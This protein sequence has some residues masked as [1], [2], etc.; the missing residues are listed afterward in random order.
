MGEKKEL[1]DQQL[2]FKTGRVI[3]DHC[4]KESSRIVLKKD[5]FLTIILLPFGSSRRKNLEV[6]LKG[7]GSRVEILGAILG[8]KNEE[9]AINIRT[10]HQGLR[11]SA[12]SH[13]RAVLF[14][15]SQTRFLGMIRIEKGANKTNSLLENR[16]L[17][18]GEKAKAT[19]DPQLEIEADEVKASHAATIG[20]VNDSQI[21]YLQS[22]G[23]AAHTALRMVV[24]GFFEPILKKILDQKIVAEIQ[25][26]LWKDVLV[27]R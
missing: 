20:R 21:F 23:I 2:G 16:V 5:E 11:T 14:G 8:K 25:G 6:C 13:V 1:K 24:E 4:Q 15:A 9:S 22:R 26:E 7:D 3:I 10:V 19:S 17:I 12:Y 27:S 18:L